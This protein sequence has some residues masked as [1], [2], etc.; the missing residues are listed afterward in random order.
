MRK[1]RSTIREHFH[2][3]VATTLLTLV[4]SWPTILYVFRADILWL[5]IGPGNDANH[6]DIWYWERIMN[7]LAER[8]YTNVMYYPEGISLVHHPFLQQPAMVLRIVMQQFMPFSNAFNIV[9][10]LVIFSNALAAYLY[11]LWLLK[12]KWA[13]LI[14]AV[15]FGFSPH[16]TNN[17]DQLH[18]ATMASVALAVYFFH[19]GIVE[20]KSLL[21]V[22]A[23][24]IVGLTSTVPPYSFACLMMTLAAVVIVF[25]VRRWRDLRFWRDIGLLALFTV[26]SSASSIYPMMADSEGLEEALEF[27]AREQ[28]YDLV[29]A[30]VNHENPLFGPPLNALLDTPADA[31]IS[32]SSYIGMVPLA[33]V[34]I[35]LFSRST[36]WAM[37]P[38]LILAAGFFVLRLGSTLGINGVVYPDI[39][40]PKYYLNEI[41]PSVFKAFSAT[42]RFNIGFFLPFCI[43]AGYGIVALRAMRPQAA[44]PLIILLLVGLITIEYY[45]P[46]IDR[47]YNMKEYEY[48]NWLNRESAD[49]IRLVNVPM[50]RT[51]A[52]RYNLHQVFNGFP[53]ATGSISREP[54]SAFDYI[55]AN[56]LLDSWWSKAPLSCGVATRDLYLTA[57]GRLES[58][59]FSHVVFHQEAR[60]RD[61]IVDGLANAQPSY[62]DDY[63][64]IYRLEDLRDRCPA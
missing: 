12:D 58:D 62:R 45:T 53:H 30:F 4:M 18:D 43:L 23:G 6:W 37:L 57:L 26:M 34:C 55:G 41:F 22:A 29:S 51:N 48:I 61:L 52:K 39:L 36:R 56:P 11:A 50:E 32:F 9:F 47:V 31:K 1:L 63:V 10:L 60:Y 59:G 54:D 40:L 7:G 33:L 5:P 17:P 15:V 19:R 13:A 21:V 28:T 27:H 46:I 2:F 25:A 24:L 44:R 3:I 35:G 49:E 8:D 38:W 20:K 14:S 64:W 42:K 16:A